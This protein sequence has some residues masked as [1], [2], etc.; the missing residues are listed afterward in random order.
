M[1][2]NPLTNVLLGSGQ[3]SFGGH[4][5][6]K[7][8]DSDSESEVSVP[9]LSIIKF[10]WSGPR[11]GTGYTESHSFP[12]VGPTGAGQHS[13]EI[14]RICRRRKCSA[15]S[16]MG[17]TCCYQARPGISRRESISI[18]GARPTHH[19]FGGLDVADRTLRG[20]SAYMLICL[21][22]C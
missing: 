11:G 18:E 21:F 15:H 17:N 1:E 14:H 3:W 7:H 10:I 19:H 4:P 13:S 12:Q 5:V 16:G 8:P 6:S 22:I 20:G 2:T 9:Q